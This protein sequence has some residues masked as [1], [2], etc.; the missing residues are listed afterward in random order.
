MTPISDSDS[1]SA[2]AKASLK[3]G[4]KF[5]GVLSWGPD[6]KGYRAAFKMEYGVVDNQGTGEEAKGRPALKIGLEW[7]KLPSS[8]RK[9]TENA[10]GFIEGMTIASGYSKTCRKNPSKEI[11]V[12]VTV[13]TPERGNII[14][15]TPKMTLS[16]NDITFPLP[17]PPLPTSREAAES[18]SF[19]S[20]TFFQSHINDCTLEL[21]LVKLEK[22]VGTDGETSNCYSIH[23]VS[24]CATGC[25]PTQTTPVSVRFHCLKDNESIDLAETQKML[26]KS[27]DLTDTIDAHTACSCHSPQCAS[28]STTEQT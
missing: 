21:K 11:T 7:P 25:S 1:W 10:V 26:E 27:E 5:K 3:G 22:S 28:Q 14:V 4:H 16:F 20:H 6:C 2:C 24:R 19:L 13:Q 18:F 12:Y 17:V 8:M 9:A 23:P 15:Q